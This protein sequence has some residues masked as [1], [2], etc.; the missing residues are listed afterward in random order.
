MESYWVGL[1]IKNVYPIYVTLPMVSMSACIGLGF[2]I[3][4]YNSKELK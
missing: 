2:L 1:L 4:F 3:A